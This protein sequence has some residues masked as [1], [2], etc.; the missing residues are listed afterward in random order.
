MTEAAPERLFI[1]TNILVYVSWPAAPLH[2][3]ARATLAAY[4]EAG[5][6]LVISRQVLREFLATL[7][8]NFSGAK[9]PNPRRKAR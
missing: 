8:G 3:Q 4:V 5:T 6:L 2:Q 9:P 7:W 1:D